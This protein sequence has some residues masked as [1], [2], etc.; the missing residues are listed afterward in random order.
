MKKLLSILLTFVLMFTLAACSILGNTKDNTKDVEK[1]VTSFLDAFTNLEL[2][3]IEEYFVDGNKLPEAITEFDVDSVLE[4]MTASMSEELSAYAADFESIIIDM[5]N[6]M[7]EKLSYEIKSIERADKGNEYIVSFDLT[8][9][10]VDNVDFEAIIT[11]KMN[12]TVMND[13]IMKMFE[14]GTISETTSQEEMMDLI[15]SEVLPVI[16]D[17]VTTIDYDVTTEEKELIVIESEDGKWLIDAER[18]D[19]DY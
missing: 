8:T 5:I 12:E 3:G 6:K 2:D 1:T 7:K 18:S 14:E 9:P 10:D 13:M 19:L 15:M 4:E 17:T 11:E 16:R